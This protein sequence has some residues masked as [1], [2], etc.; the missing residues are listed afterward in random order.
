MTNQALAPKNS[1]WGAVQQATAHGEGIWWVSTASHG[2]FLVS[3]AL[4]IPAPY[5]AFKTFA[6]EPG[7]YEEDCDAAVV[8]L[9]F[10]DRFP[11]HEVKEAAAFVVAYGSD[12]F[13]EAVVAAAKELM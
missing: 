2:G 13:G 4:K 3:P 8:P 10:P 12:Y 1:P 11:A 7:A 5:A 6:D 9:A